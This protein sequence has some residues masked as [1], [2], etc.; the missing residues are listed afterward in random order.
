V[1]LRET[2]QS[3]GLCGYYRRGALAHPDLGF[4]F[5]RSY[6][7][8]GYGFECAA[9]ALGHGFDVLG[10]ERVVAIVSPGNHVS[11]G[12]LRKL[13]FV[14]ERQMRMSADADEVALFA[15]S[16]PA[17]KDGAGSEET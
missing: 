6:R 11:Q 13:G 2:G 3:I 9:W 15:V 1:A 14:F 4:A 7:G 10:F 16:R 17:G 8:Q 12:L 5:L